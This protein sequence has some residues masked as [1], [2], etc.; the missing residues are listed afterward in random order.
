MVFCSLNTFSLDTSLGQ[1]PSLNVWV[2]VLNFVFFK[3]YFKFF[4]FKAA[5][6]KIVIMTLF[7]FV[8]LNYGIMLTVEEYMRQ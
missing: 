8:L 7:T 5:L 3:N 1:L 2:D 6:Y 4:F